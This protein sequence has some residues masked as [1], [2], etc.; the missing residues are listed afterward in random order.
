MAAKPFRPYGTPPPFDLDEYKD[1]F[2]IWKKKWE[3][4]LMLSTID[5][6]VEM[7][8]R[9]KYTAAIL[10]S[11]MSSETLAVILSAGLTATELHDPDKIIE[12]IENRCN[13]GRN[14]LVWR[15]QF[16]NRRQRPNET[17][18]DW[19]CDLRTLARKCNFKSDCCGACEPTRILDQ[20]IAGVNNEDDRRRLLEKGSETD[21]DGEPILDL[22]SAIELLRS[23]E[24]ARQQASTLKSGETISIQQTSKSAYKKGKGKQPPPSKQKEN[25]ANPAKTKRSSSSPAGAN[26]SSTGCRYCGAKRRCE[27]EKC[28]AKDAVCECGRTGHY[29]K[30][31]LSKEKKK[32]P[33]VDVVRIS[34]TQQV[35]AVQMD[36]MVEIKVRPLDRST[37]STGILFLPDTGAE[38]DAIPPNIFWQHFR[39]IQLRD[40]P[41]PETATGAPIRNDGTFQATLDWTADD[42]G[43]RPTTVSIHVL[44]HLKQ[45][46]LSKSTQRKLGMLP[47]HYPHARIRQVDEPT[48]PEAETDSP[49][50]YST[51]FSV[52]L[53]LPRS[54]AQFVA[55]V[56]A[57]P[58]LERVQRDLKQ[59]QEE[60]PSIFDGQCRPMRGPPCHFEIGKGAIPRAIRGSRPVAV[61]LMQPLRE[62][63][64]LL[65]SQEIIRKVTLPTAWVHPI[66]IAF[67]AT[68]AI[69]L[70]VDFRELNKCIIRPRFET[71]TPFQAVRTIPTGMRFFSTIDALKGYHQVPLDDES[72][73][74]TTFST[75]FGRYQYLRLPF[76]VSH[77]GDDYSRRVSE[78]FDDLPFTRRVIEDVL[79]FSPTYEEHLDN[80]HDLLKRA[81]EHNIA[82]NVPKMVFAQPSVKFGG[83]IID[84]TGF[85]PDP[86][87]IRAISN[88]PTPQ[89]I[90][91]LRSF[92]GLCQQVGNFSER[93]S[94]ALLPLAPLLKKGLTWEWTTTHDEA[95]KSAREALSI[96]QD[97]SFYDQH[98]PTALHVDASLLNGLGFVLK[99]QADDGS[100]RIVQA[101]SRFLSSAESRYAM[102]ELECLGAAW[103]M[104]KCRQ[105]LEGL[106][107]FDLV[108][109]HKPLVPILNDYSLDKLDNPRLLRL[110]LKMQ[111]YA[112]KARW[113]PGKENLDA[114]ALS[115]APVDQATP[116]DELAEGHHSYRARVAVI[117]AIDGSDASVVDPVLEKIRTAAN[118]DPVMTQLRETILQGFPNSKCNLPESLRSFWNVRERLS[119]D[120]TDD[121]IVCGARIVIPKSLQRTIL[122]DLLQMHQGAT[123]LRQRARLSVYWPNMDNEIANLVRECPECVSRLPSLPPEPLRPHQPASRPFEIVH[124]DLGSFRG[125]HFLVIVDQ[126]SGWPHVVNFPDNHTSARRIV[127]AVRTFFTSVGVPIKFFADNGP[128]FSSAEFRTFLQDW[129][130]T[131]GF[132]SPYFS[133]SNGIAEAG[134]KS[135]KKLI[136]GSFRAGSFDQDLFSKALLLF[137]NAPRSGAASPAQMIFNRPVRDSLPAHRRSFAPEWQTAAHILDQRARRTEEKR[138]EYFNRK[139]H[140]LPELTVGSHVLIQHPQTKRWATPGVIVEVGP[141]RDYLIKTPAG[142]IFRRNRR[143]LRRLIP[144]MPAKAA[145][146]H[147]AAERPIPPPPVQPEPI[148]PPPAQQQPV[149]PVRRSGRAKQPS[150]RYPQHTWTN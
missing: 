7:Q 97:L 4:Y 126:F 150:S 130:V 103:A 43:S 3:I 51:P 45:A 50:I 145:H 12:I 100:W 144:V 134:I 19:L 5:V 34:S 27:R 20:L 36:D 31:C 142:R 10:L 9:E 127:D 76:G 81:N 106:P 30:C 86:E 128:P 21:E 117:N 94:T 149:P 28:P 8:E 116:S 11:S 32:P 29:T 26:K 6:C 136:A 93:I 83:Y 59:F 56:Q 105:F 64:D 35:A 122:K 132:S 98:R 82:L 75:P 138:A 25:G 137:R 148:P 120:S 2:E 78:V 124:A 73:A 146:R 84:S 44:H 114:D 40:A 61:P 102:I 70:C 118:N 101:G 79:V 14:P 139:A 80:V 1:S 123:K 74:L 109:D 133:Q 99:Q 95:F 42:N 91:D 13:A 46:V 58:T 16:A 143:L 108:T 57:T 135:A 89:N 23:S 63:L 67:K 22:D 88:F 33:A 55:A 104:K 77:A 49:S 87:L 71:A 37:F 92:F 121:M 38:I 41:S 48:Q 18:N 90:T 96:I 52:L 62:E 113:I 17:V 54:G 107:A 66:V 112:F 147:P 65:E 125:R 39:G 60:F 24:A 141:N 68:G 115:R 140:P 15:Q 110:R 69:R 85:R 47:D 53:N 111:R 119:I 129:G 131:A 72:I